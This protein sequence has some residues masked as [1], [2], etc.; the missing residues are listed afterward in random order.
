MTIEE[1]EK[2]FEEEEN[3]LDNQS[4]SIGRGLEIMAKYGEGGDVETASGYEELFAA[5]AG[6][7]LEKSLEVMKE[8]DIQTLIGL[9]WGIKEDSFHHYI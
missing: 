3:T 9:G 7:D 5:P 4:N 1:Y 2:K 8:A 6:L